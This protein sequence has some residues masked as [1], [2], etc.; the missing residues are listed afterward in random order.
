M[1]HQ[2][3]YIVQKLWHV[4]STTLQSQVARDILGKDI[5]HAFERGQPS[6]LFGI[7]IF[8]LVS[9]GLVFEGFAP[10]EICHDHF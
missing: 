10:D 7:D 6:H 1:V 3:A 9:K 2:I 8:T 4:I 5:C